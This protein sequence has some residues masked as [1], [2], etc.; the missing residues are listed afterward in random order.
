MDKLP[1]ELF[2]QIIKEL[3]SCQGV[4]TAW[5]LRGVCHL[6]KATITTEI[7]TYQRRSAFSLLR[8]GMHLYLENH[9]KLPSSRAQ[10]DLASMVDAI[11]NLILTLVPINA[12]SAAQAV[13][14]ATEVERMARARVA[15]S[16]AQ[17]RK[18]EDPYC[19][20]SYVP[21]S[22]EMKTR[23]LLLHCALC[24]AIE[25]ENTELLAHLVD[26][27][28]SMWSSSSIFVSPICVAFQMGS[29]RIVKCVLEYSKKEPNPPQAQVEKIIQHSQD[30]D[31]V[32]SNMT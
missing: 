19:S 25:W 6:F 22:P 10:N 29:L 18:L 2:E 13:R 27:G 26:N 3:V 30:P 23:E 11:T 21:F 24:I 15:Q 14:M 31:A 1:L 17:L 32:D 7:F 20:T 8:K 5:K 9:S 4:V 12:E 28:A 16:V